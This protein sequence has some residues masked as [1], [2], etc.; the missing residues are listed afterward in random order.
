[1]ARSADAPAPFGEQP[2]GEP[3][4]VGE[5]G[6][7]RPA[8]SAH[9]PNRGGR[10]PRA[11]IHSLI[12]VPMRARGIVLVGRQRRSLTLRIFPTERSSDSGSTIAASTV[13]PTPS[14]T[15]WA[16]ARSAAARASGVAPGRASARTVR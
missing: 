2:R 11:G 5:P 7:S 12:A 4:A 14:L 6:V 10:V 1:M 15:A 9:D 13:S 16:M 3:L 8:L